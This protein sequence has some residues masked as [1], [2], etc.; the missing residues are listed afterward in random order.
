VELEALRHVYEQVVGGSRRL[1][2][3][4]GEPGIG[5]T[6]L[7]AQFARRAHDEGAIVLH[8]R[9]DEEALLAQQPFVEALRHYVCACPPRE[10]ADRL[11]VITGELRR[12]V[13]E[14]ADRIPDLPEP[15]AGDPDGA[16]S[17]LFEAVASLLCEAAQNTPIVLVLDDLHW[18]DQATLLLLKYVICYPRQARLMVLGTYR[19][20]ELDVDHP[21]CATLAE[22]DRERLLERR[23]LTPLDAS[24][25]SELVGIYTGDEASFELGQIVYDR[26]EGNA[27][28]VVEMLRHLTESGAIAST[29]AE[30]E[31][32]VTPGRLAVPEGL[33][34]S[35]P[36]ASRASA[37][38]PTISSWQ[39]RSWAVH[40][41][42]TCSS[43]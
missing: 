9:C 23:A 5:K 35:S 42:S 30:P 17:R 27:F 33:K 32:G 12:I 26:T 16:R 40:L 43:A 11:Q 6:R 24:A 31:P 18:A 36:T 2:L 4:C 20:T 38:Q 34:A 7:A 28:F 15:L 21:L 22:L 37:P 39:P 3:L 10:L 19:E 14:L 41:N 8:G 1:V 29:T 25:V 13:P